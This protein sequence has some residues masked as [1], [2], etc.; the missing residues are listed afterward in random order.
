[1]KISGMKIAGVKIGGTK[2]AGMNI[3]GMKINAMKFD[4]LRWLSRP[5]QSSMPPTVTRGSETN[6]RVCTGQGAAS[7]R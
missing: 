1:M 6:I 4:G 2:I 7:Q 3:A 5:G